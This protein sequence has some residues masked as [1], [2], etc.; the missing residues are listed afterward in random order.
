M[1]NVSPV[2]IVRDCVFFLFLNL[3]VGIVPILSLRTIVYAN[4]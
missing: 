2:N 4:T 1:V 3:I